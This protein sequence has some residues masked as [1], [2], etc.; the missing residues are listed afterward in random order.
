METKRIQSSD[1][2]IAHY[3]NINGVNK[4]HNWDGAA[5]IPKGNKRAAEYYL[6]GI[7]HT[8][9]EWLEKKKSVNGIPWHKTAAGKAAGARV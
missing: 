3:V 1:G 4:M 6:F 2:T 7:K 9:D 8:K 5:L